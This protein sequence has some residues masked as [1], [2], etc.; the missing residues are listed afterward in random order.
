M[1]GMGMF[2]KSELANERV[3]V[4]VLTPSEED[5]HSCF[6]DNTH[7]DIDLNYKGFVNVLKGSYKGKTY[8]TSIYSLLSKDEK[9]K[10]D[11]KITSISAKMKT[12]NDI[13]KSTEHFD[14]QI[15]PNSGNKKNIEDIM[16]ELITLGDKMPSVGAEYG[17][18]FTKADVTDPDQSARPN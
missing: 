11:T 8:G 7:R 9:A 14:Y 13:A 15:K 5:E 12:M 6:S 10:L 17:I 4:A 18:N 1:T 16:D 2:I 3:M